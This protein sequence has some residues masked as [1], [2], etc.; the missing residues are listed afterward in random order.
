MTLKAGVVQRVFSE[1]AQAPAIPRRTTRR[2]ADHSRS[3]GYCSVG[4]IRAVRI[5]WTVDA[6][7][8]SSLILILAWR[9]VRARRGGTVV[10]IMFTRTAGYTGV[11]ISGRKL[12]YKAFIASVGQKIDMLRCVST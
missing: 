1:A 10:V 6:I 3:T 2:I 5:K 12:T 11:S 4:R 8:F 7:V 9:A